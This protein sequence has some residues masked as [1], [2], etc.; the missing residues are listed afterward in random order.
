MQEMFKAFANMVGSFAGLSVVLLQ[1]IHMQDGRRFVAGDITR[2]F[3]GSVFAATE[4]V[5]AGAG[6]HQ[7]MVSGP[8]RFDP[9]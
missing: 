2:P 8:G 5:R 4:R 6:C 1:A 7:Q 9:N 3:F